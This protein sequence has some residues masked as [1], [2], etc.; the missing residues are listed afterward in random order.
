MIRDA[1]VVRYHRGGNGLGDIV[2]KTKLKLDSANSDLK[3][4]V[5]EITLTTRLPVDWS[6]VD[7]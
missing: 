2:T 1:Y 3:I 6:P 4:P 5:K 7:G